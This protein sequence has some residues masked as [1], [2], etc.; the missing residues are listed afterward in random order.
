[1]TRIAVLSDL[2][3]SP[4][5]PL[6]S[7]HAGDELADLLPRLRSEHGVDT[8]VLDGDIF[9]FL[10]LPNATAMLHPEQVP[11]LVGQTFDDIKK[12][13]WGKKIFDELG[14]LARAGTTIV[15]LPGNHDPE[16][17]HPEAMPILRARCGLRRDLPPPRARRGWPSPLLR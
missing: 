13:E 16:L 15:V 17:A 5:G 10:A 6:A 11:E 1:M 2:H 7:F 8:L 9:D 12:I 4:P 14:A 3:I